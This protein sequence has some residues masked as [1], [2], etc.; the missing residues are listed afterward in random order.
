MKRK[1]TRSGRT[2]EGRLC[3][4]PLIQ[5]PNET[6]EEFAQRHL[7]AGCEEYAAGIGVYREYERELNQRCKHAVNGPEESNT[8]PGGVCAGA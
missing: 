4:V 2:C 8:H 7:C 3:G 1:Q 6:W 5:R